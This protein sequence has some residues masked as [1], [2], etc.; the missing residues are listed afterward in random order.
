MF[1][2]LNILN[3]SEEDKL[4]LQSVT[5]FWVV[6][7][8]ACSKNPTIC[9]INAL[10]HLR[11]AKAFLKD[12]LNSPPIEYG[13]EKLLTFETLSSLF[14]EKAKMATLMA[15]N[16]KLQQASDEREEN[17][18]Q[19][20]QNKNQI[21]NEIQKQS[22]D[23]IDQI[24]QNLKKEE[25]QKRASLLAHD[26]HYNGKDPVVLALRN[27]IAEFRNEQKKLGEDFNQEKITE[28]EYKEKSLRIDQTI[29]GKENNIAQ[30]EFQKDM[31]ELATYNDI[32]LSIG[33]ILGLPKEVMQVGQAVGASIQV[34]NA[35]GAMVIAGV[36][37]PTMVLQAIKGVG[38]FINVISGV[39]STDQVMIGLLNDLKKGQIKMMNQ[40]TY[41]HHD[42]KELKL[43][44]NYM[45]QI[46]EMGLEQIA[47]NFTEI[48]DQIEK[49]RIDIIDAVK[50]NKNL[51][52]GL[53]ETIKT[54]FLTDVLIAIDPHPVI[55]DRHVDEILF[56]C[57]QFRKAYERDPTVGAVH[58]NE[59]LHC[60]SQARDMDNRNRFL[61]H[62][63][64]HRSQNSL[65]IKKLIEKGISFN[66][67][68]FSKLT[69]Y[70][71]KT[72][73]KRVGLLLDM[74][75]W[76]KQHETKVY[77]LK[78]YMIENPEQKDQLR[79]YQKLLADQ[80]ESPLSKKSQED[81][82]INS[83]FYDEDLKSEE[84]EEK[85]HFKDAK[86]YDIAFNGY[87][88]ISSQ[89]PR[90]GYRYVIDEKR[91]DIHNKVKIIN[92]PGKKK[93]ID[94][95]PT[96]LQNMCRAVQYNGNLSKKARKHIQSAY[97]V[98]QYYINK[99]NS[100]FDKNFK[101]RMEELDEHYEAH[102][103]EDKDSEEVS[104]F[105]PKECSCD[106]SHTKGRSAAVFKHLTDQKYD[107]YRILKSSNKNILQEFNANQTDKDILEKGFFKLVK[108]N[109]AK[110]Q[111]PISSKKQDYTEADLTIDIQQED[112]Q[113]TYARLQDEKGCTIKDESGLFSSEDSIKITQEFN[114]I[115]RFG[116]EE[117]QPKHACLFKRHITDGIGVGL[118]IG[119]AIGSFIGVVADALVAGAGT[120][121]VI[122]GA[123]GGGLG[124]AIDGEEAIYSICKEVTFQ[125]GYD[126]D[127]MMTG[128]SSTEEALGSKPLVNNFG[129]LH[130]SYYQEKPLRS[131]LDGWFHNTSVEHSQRLLVDSLS[132]EAF[133]YIKD[134]YFD[135]P[136]NIHYTTSYR[137]YNERLANDPNRKN[138]WKNQVWKLKI[139]SE[140]INN[141]SEKVFQ[142]VRPH[143]IYPYYFTCEKKACLA[144]ENKK[145]A[146]RRAW[147]KQATNEIKHIREELRKV[148]I[149]LMDI[150]RFHDKSKA[151]DEHRVND[152]DEDPHLYEGLI[153]SVLLLDTLSKSSYGEA[154]P[155]QPDLSQFLGGILSQLNLLMKAKD[156]ANQIGIIKNMAQLNKFPEIKNTIEDNL[157][158]LGYP[159]MRQEA[160]DIIMNRDYYSP[161]ECKYHKEG[162]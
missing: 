135:N 53:S 103:A 92:D 18:Q 55:E 143:I 77:S 91:V 78:K 73:E 71:E 82:L 148:S 161:K 104:Y 65:Y 137:N 28:H 34:T 134:Y 16:V 150:S 69:G 141:W 131:Y 75:E 64:Y 162:E 76:L 17:A 154:L 3:K 9:R 46:L 7:L 4:K 58:Q 123:L 153:K 20:K 88:K 13:S 147:H 37:D 19:I 85:D 93:T 24:D 61:L 66:L 146:D 125:E 90:P 160:L 99:L 142:A 89:L 116:E 140:T 121:T 120:F 110:K 159:H 102:E 47:K 39:P 60:Q 157:T 45:M 100:K 115:N 31:N 44:I 11:N 63:T 108:G 68:D 8:D 2:D 96:H 106:N 151:K 155:N 97:L 136:Q 38:L 57:I 62:N 79:E 109:C 10:P 94:Y 5:N 129:L 6:E 126:K 25:Y 30:Y 42:I 156:I 80:K 74:T 124:G 49:S 149:P 56:E 29:K 40:I 112:F 12:K 43:K 128:D 70:F 52:E 152:K 67:I 98:Y 27:Q 111:T 101:A 51:I 41:M 114:V 84:E 35:V 122:G 107:L 1:D 139:D 87:A 15:N 72:V 83:I 50:E 113:N 130:F 119:G 118:L 36:S 23:Q 145:V 86:F 127:T 144:F 95:D 133:S 117:I 14:P 21:I 54:D 132:E 105:N 59:Y 26:P 48:E 138:I 22:Q 158:G 32:V 81:H 33:S